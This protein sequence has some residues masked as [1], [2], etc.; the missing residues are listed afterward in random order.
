M[1]KEL[2]VRV[3]GLPPSF[4]IAAAAIETDWGTSRVVADG[5]ALYKQVVWHSKEG[6]NPAD[7]KEDLTYRIKT[8]PD[9]YAAMYDFALK[10]NTQPGF[11]HFRDYRR[12]L[13]GRGSYLQ[14]TTLAHALIWNSP[15]QNYA[16]IL[17]YTIAFYELNVIDKSLLDSKMIAKELPPALEQLRLSPQE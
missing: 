7:E 13:R 8:Y 3:D 4:F 14:G 10:I 11:S 2:L 12:E 5:N 15:L 9:L 6:L 1:L 16:G 17:E